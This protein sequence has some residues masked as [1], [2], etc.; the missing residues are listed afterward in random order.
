MT[1]MELVVTKRLQLRF[2]LIAAFGAV[3][4]SVSWLPTLA[5]A[6]VGVGVAP[7]YPSALEVGDTNKAVSVTITNTSDGPQAGGTLTL[8]NIRHTPSCGSTNTPCSPADVD[9]DVFLVKGPATGR[10]GTACDGKT[11]SI[12]SPDATT[13][14]VEFTPS[15][16]AVVLQ[17]PGGANDS[18]TID[19]FV[20][21][22]RLPSK[23]ASVNGG[24]QTAQLA[25]VSAL[26]SVGPVN[27]TATGSSLVTSTQNT[28]GL[29]APAVN[30][31]IIG[32]VAVL[33]GA[34]GAA[35]LRRKAAAQA[36]RQPGM[37]RP[38]RS[39]YC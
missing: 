38:S 2:A 32:I 17:P 23:D 28:P 33:L 15:G 13:G 9:K 35:R 20:D 14:E 19:F 6:G 8:S 27:G 24:L 18:C 1:R 7:T 29:P 16:G 25:R 37:A 26:A 3:L 21:M 22:L 10:T 30:P 31:A 39:L 36:V 34:Y 5:Y 12:G 11:F 4:A